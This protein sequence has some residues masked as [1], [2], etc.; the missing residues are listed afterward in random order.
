MA[1]RWHALEKPSGP[2][3]WP[4]LRLGFVSGS[5]RENTTASA[6]SGSKA[7][8]AKIGFSRFCF[9][10]DGRFG[11][12]STRYNQAGATASVGLIEPG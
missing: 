5:D 8:V 1:N 7:D 3:V 10:K 4:G 9:C 6:K 12:I 2:P 11:L